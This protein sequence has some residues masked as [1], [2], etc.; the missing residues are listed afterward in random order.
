M[1]HFPPEALAHLRHR[2]GVATTAELRTLG[3]TEHG[4]RDLRESG[5]LE[6]VMHGVYRI[7]AVPFDE[8]AR[9]AAVCARHP[10]ATIA[11]PT[12][13]RLWDLRR[14]PPDRRV[15]VI[16]GPASQRSTD[17]WIVQYRTAA[18]HDEDRILRSDGIVVT[19]RARTALDL[20]RFVGRTAQ[21]S[22]IEQVA[23]EGRLT[24][25]DLRR[26][27]VDWMSSQRPWV[28]MYLELLERR[29]QGGAAD[30][31][32]EMRVG[33]ALATAGVR[34]LHR[35]HS[36]D[37]PGYGPARFDLAVVDLEWAIEVDMFPTHRE[38]EG[39]R[40]D[41]ARDVAAR[42]IGWDVTRLGPDLLGSA[43]TSTI[44]DLVR[45]Y[46]LRRSQR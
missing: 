43:F 21:L 11:G 46:R 28:R 25:V 2:H 8:F 20:G 5:N 4:I 35:Q 39:R 1:A 34:G 42:S 19:S 13:G 23:S 40:A 32:D 36:I 44:A 7:P 29:L 9:C 30:S 37:L 18:I 15:H 33:D 38:T 26:V 3:L 14:L 27:A 16:V 31:H 24:D 41:R 6:R 12:A 17:R 22:I 10:D 45:E